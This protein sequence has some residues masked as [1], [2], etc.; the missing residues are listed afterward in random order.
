MTAGETHPSQDTNLG[1]ASHWA[2]LYRLSQLLRCV[3]R[4]VFLS[5]AL[6]VEATASLANTSPDLHPDQVTLME[7]MNLPH[8]RRQ[9]RL[10]S[11]AQGDE[12]TELLLPLKE[13]RLAD[14]C[15]GLRL[16]TPSYVPL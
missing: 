16:Y 13:V 4:S 1:L 5:A 6:H 15:S 11:V 8:L 10:S 7:L 12:I 9:H 14:A 3:K 2:A